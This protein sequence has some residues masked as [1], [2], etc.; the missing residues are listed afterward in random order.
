[1]VHMA[2]SARAAELARERER[3]IGLHLNL[4]QA[5]DAVGVPIGI[6]ERQRQLCAHFAHLRAR[7][8]LPSASPSIHRLVAD[9]VNDQLEEFERLYGSAPTH[10]DSHHHVH[11]CPDVFLSQALGRGMRVRQTL[12]PLPWTHGP[13]TLARRLKHRQLARRFLTTDRFWGARE[14]SGFDGAIPIATAVELARTHTV[15]VMAHPSFPGELRVLLSPDW[16]EA[17]AGSTLGSYALLKA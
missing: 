2:D 8:W 13:E 11:V 15:E 7:R 6:R 12:S 1:M 5:F 10:L 16:V 14:L 4:T 3:P 17:L 9:G